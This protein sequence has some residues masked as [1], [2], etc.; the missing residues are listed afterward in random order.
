[1]TPASDPARSIA[2]PRDVVRITRLSDALELY[3]PPLRNVGAAVGFGAF[4][5]LSIALP[6]AAVTGIGVTDAPGVNSWLALILIAGFA[7][8]ILVFGFVFI[9]LAA[10]LVA[11]SLTVRAGPEC[12]LTE[13][14][15]F[16]LTVSGRTFPCS[17]IA[18]LVA[19]RPRQFQSHFTPEARYRLIARHRDPHRGSVV[20]A[21]SLPGLAATEQ[22]GEAIAQVSG[23]SFKTQ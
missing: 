12:I 2:L 8:P 17:E 22:M 16:G 9:G 10:Y 11:N 18:A 3:F 6:V 15:L 13:R 5:A 1:M 20:V 7:L 23:I 19:Q 4:G 21:E 14:R